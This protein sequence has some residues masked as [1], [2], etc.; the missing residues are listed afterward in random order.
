[1]YPRVLIVLALFALV[2]C[3]T[4]R[5]ADER[6][7]L[8]F[9]TEPDSLDPAYSKDVASGRLCGYIYSNLVRF[10]ANLR[11]VPDLSDTWSVSPDGLTYTF[12]VRR[13][14]HFASGRTVTAEDVKASFERVLDPETASPRTWVLDRILGAHEYMDRKAKGVAGI[15]AHGDAIVLKLAQPFAP[16]LGFLSMPAAAVVDMDAVKKWGPDFPRH[17]SGSGPWVVLSWVK[18]SGLELVPNPRHHF[19]APRAKGV[20]ARIVK[21]AITTVTEMRVGQ[22]DL[23]EVPTAELTTILKDPRWSGCV[24]DRPGMN[25]FYAGFNC[26]KGPF[27]DRE[28]RRAAAMAVDRERIVRTV[29]DG[30][31]VAARGPIPPGL[32]GYDPAYK[33]LPYDP[34]RAAQVVKERYHGERIRLLQPDGKDVLEVTQMVQ[35]YLQQAGF[36]VDLVPYEANT[37]RKR[38][39]AAEFD[40]YYYNWFADYADA[41]N[42]LFPL[43]HSSRKGGGGNGARYADAQVDEM[44]V[45]MQA[46]ADDEARRKLYRQVEEKVVDDAPRIFL[47]HRKQLWLRQPWVS[48]FQV[49]P[50]FNSD[51]LRETAV[52]TQRLGVF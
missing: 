7:T 31:A 25:I 51:S 41:E 42:F 9:S 22:A 19:G 5:R 23:T 48:G 29:R 36:N 52:D 46:T 10:D 28:L 26:E 40:M 49:Y 33:G 24:V 17:E 4:G 27:T 8:I 16:F 44:L 11:L 32:F 39:D 35:A 34:Q 37:F 13:D 47:F 21:E 2:G 45:K 12:H 43:F 50:V 15:D 14:A 6:L 1:M 3:G 38:V 18:D 20:V 30:M